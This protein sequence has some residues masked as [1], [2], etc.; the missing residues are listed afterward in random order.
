MKTC[1]MCEKE[2]PISH[3][4]Y[5]VEKAD[6]SDALVCRD[7][8]DKTLW[9]DETKVCGCCDGIGRLPVGRSGSQYCPDCKG[10]G[11]VV[12]VAS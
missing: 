7:C 5:F 8:Y 12:K 2:L 6:G 3:S 4:D 1:S 11:I 10:V 9:S